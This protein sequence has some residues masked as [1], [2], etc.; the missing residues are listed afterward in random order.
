MN[1]D[2]LNERVGEAI[3]HFWNKRASQQRNDGG[4]D[5]VKYAGSRG[6]V[7][8]GGH[9]DGFVRL[10][11]DLL[12]EV[13]ISN[14]YIHTSKNKS[15]LPGFFRPTKSWD[16]VVVT[17]KT[18]IATIEF[19][20]QVGSFGNNYNNRVE[21]AVGNATDLHT[22]YREGA[23]APS[24][25]PWLGYLMLIEESKGSTKQTR[26]EEPHFNVFA[27]WNNASYAKRYEVFCKK[28]VRERMYNAACFLMSR[29]E[30]GSKGKFTEPSE[31]IGVR[32]FF[33]SLL[34]HAIAV[35]ASEKTI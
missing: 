35:S 6:A 23:F 16:L 14:A 27:E 26:V 17:D 9:L 20:S 8:G 18:L 2:N 5:Q 22:A 19:K 25:P 4:G 1:L 3:A 12:T 28:L 32:N 30:S 29:N 13:G 15:V 10:T 7:V 33:A 31:E 24:T 21:E 34:G 11:H